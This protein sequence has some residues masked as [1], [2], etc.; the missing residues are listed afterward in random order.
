MSDKCIK[1][2]KPIIDPQNQTEC[3]S[4]SNGF[5]GSNPGICCHCVSD[6]ENEIQSLKEQL[7][8]TTRKLDLLL[9]AATGN[10]INYTYTN[11]DLTEQL[12]MCISRIIR[13]YNHHCG[14]VGFN[15]ADIFEAVDGLIFDFEDMKNAKLIQD[16]PEF[17]VWG[18]NPDANLFFPLEKPF[19]EHA[20]PPNRFWKM[21]TCHKCGKQ[22]K[23]DNPKDVKK[24][25]TVEKKGSYNKVKPHKNSWVK[26]SD[27][28]SAL[29]KN[30]Q[31]KKLLEA[32]NEYR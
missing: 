14:D 21:K 5:Y 11:P 23:I 26:Y 12:Y 24:W 6:L 31:I 17:C 7:E 2:K 22:I 20:R 15:W 32:T 18:F 3:E 30:K 28:E 19:Y 27:V 13:Y 16:N 25:E 1:C 4:V 29:N 9:K 10:S 8:Q